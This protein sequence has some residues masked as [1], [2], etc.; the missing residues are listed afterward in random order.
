MTRGVDCLHDP[1]ERGDLHELEYNEEHS[2]GQ[3]VDLSEEQLL[4]EWESSKRDEP[5]DDERQLTQELGQES[6]DDCL[7]LELL[8]LI[9]NEELL[10]THEERPM[11][12]EYVIL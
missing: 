11:K 8:L 5:T 7:L 4:P 6:E 2:Y 9:E 1:I 12:N 10:A 3:T